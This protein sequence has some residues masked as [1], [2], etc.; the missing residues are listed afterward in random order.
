VT[1][2]RAAV[3][4]L[5]ALLAAGCAAEPPRAEPPRAA[6]VAGLADPQLSA[7]AVYGRHA[8]VRERVDVRL[9]NEGAEPVDV[10]RLQVR[11]PLFAPVPA[12]A[13]S[14]SLPPDGRARIVP[15]PFG[16]PRCEADDPAGAVVVVGVRTPAGVRDV[17]VPLV[18][19]EPGL[20]RA[21]RVACAVAAV[22]AAV[23]LDLAPWQPEQQ[24]S[25]VLTVRRRGPGRGR[26]HRGRRQRAVR[27]RHRGAGPAGGARR[28]PGRRRRAR[29]SCGPR[30]A[31]RTR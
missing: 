14:S 2:W 6:P 31:T 27:R 8:A 30:G 1:A 29:W 17:E 22:A 13:R 19:G 25:T 26:R 28:G 24:G 21:H 9:A 16:A 18:D 20:L 12:L 10:E 4:G 7:T 5:V 11:H 15:V 23:T 3:V